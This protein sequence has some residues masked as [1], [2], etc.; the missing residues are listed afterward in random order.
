MVLLMRSNGSGV[1]AMR[2]FAIFALVVVAGC[3]QLPER[4]DVASKVVRFAGVKPRLSE[5]DILSVWS[6]DADDFAKKDRNDKFGSYFLTAK[7]GNR[8]SSIDVDNL[9]HYAMQLKNQQSIRIAFSDEVCVTADDIR[10]AIG[11]DFKEN[12]YIVHAHTSGGG[13]YLKQLKDG[14]RFD[15]EERADAL[16]R[17][18][19]GEGCSSY[20]TLF[21]AW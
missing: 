5:A 6:L 16:K 10:V 17:I 7:S 21:N 12:K 18:T 4:D 19:L 14:L 20:V 3:A 13:F 8:I 15:L 1:L 9:P 2:I 11:V